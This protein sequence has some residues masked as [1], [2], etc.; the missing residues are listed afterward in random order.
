MGKKILIIDESEEIHEILGKF[1]EEKGYEVYHSFD[2]EDGIN[3][4]FK[5][6]PDFVILEILIPKK[7]GIEIVRECKI[8]PKL[9][10]IPFMFYTILYLREEEIEKGIFLKGNFYSFKVNAY[11]QKPTEPEIILKKMKEILGEEKEEKEI[12]KI[13]LIENEFEI[14]SSLKKILEEKEYVV[15][16]AMNAKEGLIKL[17]EFKPNLILLDSIL[18]D[19]D[20]VEILSKIKEKYKEI[21]VI[22]ITPYGAE[23]VIVF[24]LKRGADDYISKPLGGMREIS[25]KIEENLKKIKRTENM[26]ISKIV[27]M[28]HFLIDAYF[29]KEDIEKKLSSLEKEIEKKFLKRIEEINEKYFS[30]KENIVLIK[31]DMDLLIKN[32]EETLSDIREKFYNL[33]PE[34]E[35]FPE[36]ARELTGKI[37]EGLQKIEALIYKIKDKIYKL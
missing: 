15:E 31:N 20:G 21:P 19:A 35:K 14:V 27:E 12:Y 33:K 4:I 30:L 23:D 28:N 18:P 7:L 36:K 32:F 6:I 25:L 8:N 13:L 34:E 11:F 26:L 16:Y 17:E 1:L 5:I 10:N 37:R 9:Q 3:K 2:G 24:L 29:K 22:M